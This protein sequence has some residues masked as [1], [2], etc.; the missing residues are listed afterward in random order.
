MACTWRGRVAAPAALQTAAVLA[1]LA[2]GATTGCAV[3]PDY[4][5]PELPPIGDYTREPVPAT[6]A[7]TDTPGGAAQTL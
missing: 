1:A 2:V 7:A 3:G 5:P 6:T 4:K